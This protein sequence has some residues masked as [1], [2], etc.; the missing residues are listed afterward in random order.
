MKKEI[1]LTVAM[2][3]F[4]N[5]GFAQKPEESPQSRKDR[6]EWFNDA[7]L[8]IFIHWGIYSVY[9]IDESWSFYNN[10]ISY[11]D[12]M[13]QRKG[14]T[15][16]NYDPDAW[17]SLF[18]ESGARYAVL[19]TKHHDGMAL[20]PTKMNDLNVVK[21][22][23]AGRDL[24]TP[25][26]ESI[27]K[28]GLKAGLY[29]SI[30]DWSHPDYPE[31]TRTSK[32]FENDPKRFASF[33]DFYSG[34]LNE[35]NDLFKPDLFWFDGDW[36]YDEIAFQTDR[37]KAKLYKDNPKLI[38]N[39]RLRGGDYGTPEQGLPLTVPKEDYW[40]LCMTINNSWGYQHND[41][42]YKSAQQIISIFAD[43][44]S[45]GGN[46]LLDVGPKEDGT[47][48]AEQVE[49]L[50]EL[51]RWTSKHETAIYGSRPG[52]PRTHFNGPSTLSKDSTILYLFFDYKPN[53]QLVLKGVKNKINRIWVVGNGTKL[54]YEVFMKA[55]WSQVPGLVYIEVP[56]EILDPKMT[57]LAVLLDGKI[58]LYGDAGQVIESN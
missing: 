5:P 58:D 47:I 3:I 19:T 30:L 1:L 10:M 8:G 35:L 33:V 53:E 32:K 48:P 12:Y 57:V 16:K 18:K 20:W 55:Y 25:F 56:D 9:G 38:C 26:V 45:L 34:Q 2:L 21:S 14:F 4:L 44:I 6:M 41:K 24:V 54:K 49:V 22:T 46:L 52:I 11:E 51:G 17:A 39:S 28:Q 31:F 23:P 7:K 36:S 43:V 50:K 42:K 29:F 40:E 15:A 37:V 27:R 13:E